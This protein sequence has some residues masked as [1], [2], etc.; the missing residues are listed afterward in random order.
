MQTMIP[1]T[2]YKRQKPGLT[3][4]NEN[5]DDKNQLPKIIGLH[6]AAVVFELQ[7]GQ[8]TGV[9]THLCKVIVMTEVFL[10]SDRKHRE[11]HCW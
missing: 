1:K 8:P 9:Q 3:V 6:T 5:V 2:F 11:T 7:S 10:E 4:D